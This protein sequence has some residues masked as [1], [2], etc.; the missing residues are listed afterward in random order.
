MTSQQ[1]HDQNQLPASFGMPAIHPH[2]TSIPAFTEE[3]VRTYIS[4]HPFF[5]KA[6]GYTEPPI[7]S[8]IKF[9]TSREASALMHGAHT[10]L[11]DDAIVCYVEL[12]G[13]FMIT[14]GPAPLPAT[15]RPAPV[16][17]FHTVHEVFD[18]QTGNLLMAGGGPDQE[19]ASRHT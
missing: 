8:S 15:T 18:A 3:D 16:K 6:I 9:M 1:S 7:L 5:S 4:S 11:A 13:T 14:G 10:G 12:C 19:G 17:P 2:L